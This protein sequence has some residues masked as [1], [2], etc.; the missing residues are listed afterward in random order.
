MATLLDI[1]LPMPPSKNRLPVQRRG[2]VGVCRSKAFEAYIN[3]VRLLC[4]A[5][6]PLSGPLR[7]KVVVYGLRAN[8]DVHNRSEAVLDALQ[9]CAYENDRQVRE[10]E[11]VE[12]TPARKGQQYV[13]VRI[14]KACAPVPAPVEVLPWQS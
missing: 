2:G 1:L 9:G 14:F 6:E 5:Q 4:A 3:T 13:W 11:V 8:A 10:L 7:M 12:G